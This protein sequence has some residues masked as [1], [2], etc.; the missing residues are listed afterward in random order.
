M[1]YWPTKYQL[2]DMLAKGSFTKQSWDSLFDLLQISANTRDGKTSPGI[3]KKQRSES[4]DMILAATQ[5]PSGRNRKSTSPLTQS[6]T[7]QLGEGLAKDKIV[8]I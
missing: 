2:A 3:V 8:S 1:R 4:N 6:S 5:K 7:L